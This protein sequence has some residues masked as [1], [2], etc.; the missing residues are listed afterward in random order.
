MFQKFWK[1]C[2]TSEMVCH[3]EL[4]V[5]AILNQIG[6]FWMYYLTS[7]LFVVK[8]TSGLI[9]LTI[10]LQRDVRR[11]AV[12]FKIVL[13]AL[14]VKRTLTSGM[15]LLYVELRS[16]WVLGKGFR[17]LIKFECN[18]FNISPSSCGGDTHI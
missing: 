18:G 9:I 5:S 17:V 11:S 10:C 1:V 6:M 13:I 2:L 12:G 8:V 7:T 14:S 4:V 3:C 15:A 16:L